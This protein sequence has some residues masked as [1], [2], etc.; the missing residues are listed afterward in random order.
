MVNHCDGYLDFGVRTESAM[1]EINY[2]AFDSRISRIYD[3]F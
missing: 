2:L 1:K 3:A